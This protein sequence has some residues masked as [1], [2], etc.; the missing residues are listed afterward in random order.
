ME[1]QLDGRFV[2]QP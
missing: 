2:S 1:T